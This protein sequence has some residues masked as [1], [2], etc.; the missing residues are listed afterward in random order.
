MAVLSRGA[1]AVAASEL[2][3][4]VSALGPVLALSSVLIRRSK[5]FAEYAVLPGWPLL[6]YDHEV[7]TAKQS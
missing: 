3:P 7:P 1:V 5:V 6:G 2:A 4:V